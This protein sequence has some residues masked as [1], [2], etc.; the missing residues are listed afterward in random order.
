MLI[1]YIKH[2]LFYESIQ[3]VLLLCVDLCVVEKSTTCKDLPARISDF[4]VWNVT[5]SNVTN[6]GAKVTA[7][8]TIASWDRDTI[9]ILC[10]RKFFFIYS[11]LWAMLNSGMSHNEP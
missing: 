3:C 10:Q 7:L 9:K 1:V 5:L 11:Q 4:G 2:F 8:N 6:N